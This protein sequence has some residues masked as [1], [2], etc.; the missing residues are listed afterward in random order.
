MGV[1]VPDALDRAV[2]GLLSSN[3]YLRAFN[4][5]ASRHLFQ[6]GPIRGRWYGTTSPNRLL[7][8]IVGACRS[9][10][11]FRSALQRLASERPSAELCVFAEQSTDT[12]FGV[13]AHVWLMFFDH[14]EF[15][16]TGKLKP[17]PKVSLRTNLPDST[18]V[19]DNST[20]AVVGLL[21][22][23][24]DIS[25]HCTR[26]LGSPGP[27]SPSR[28]G[29]A[30]PAT[31][32][33]PQTDEIAAVRKELA[34]MVGLPGV[35]AQFETWINFVQVQQERRRHGLSAAHISLHMVLAGPPGTGK[36]TV[37]RLL[38][39]MYRSLGLLTSDQVV[40]T[41][42][43]GL[44]GG[45]VGQTALKVDEIFD[46]ADGG[47]LFID[48]AY[49]LA[50]GHAED[51]GR[52]A[53]EVI[54]KRMEDRRESIVVLF[55]GY[56]AE[57]QRFVASNPGLESRISRTLVFEDYSS[58]ELAEI[59]FRLT[60]Q[61]GYQLDEAAMGSARNLFEAATRQRGKSFGNARYVRSAFERT[62]ERQADRLAGSRSQ[63]ETSQLQRLAAED[64]PQPT[65]L[66][67]TR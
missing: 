55:A 37:A 7:E 59:F 27:N 61:D 62:L 46:R 29:D 22:G 52:E 10:Q 54:L 25:D 24:G 4:S 26:I 23:K 14:E 66:P 35:K 41:D 3:G 19:A 1:D 17:F 47:V 5:V 2:E 33:S 64:V 56:E 34:E 8:R 15:E 43:A 16:R 20:R 18:R 11:K 48:E 57:M 50:S 32:A 58:E 21:S 13:N 9:N 6:V 38:G 49:S 40:E 60:A 63:L 45:Y 67:A 39:R 42:R 36:T 31:L 44:V 51:F 53:I 12:F 28:S 65:D 30:Q